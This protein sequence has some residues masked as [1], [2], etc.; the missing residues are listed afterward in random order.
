MEEKIDPPP[1]MS[2][3][4]GTPID[5]GKDNLK[6]V[7]I[8]QE[9]TEP[10][11]GVDFWERVHAQ[12]ML[13]DILRDIC[14]LGAQWKVAADGQP[15]QLKK[16]D[17]TPLTRGWF[18]FVRRSIMPSSNNSEAEVK[19]EKILPNQFLRIIESTSAK[20]RLSFSS[21]IQRLCD[22]AG[23]RMEENE[24]LVPMDQPITWAKMLKV[25]YGAHVHGQGK[26][27]HQQQQAQQQEAQQQAPLK[28]HGQFGW[29]QLQMALQGM[30]AHQVQTNQEL[31]H[32]IAQ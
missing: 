13:D 26:E 17:L 28:P 5:F 1:Y 14:V 31:Q 29:Y 19:V 3:V 23:V 12:P 9:P 22:S 7:L 24:I 6:K 8:I 2:Y 30:Q 21:I 20:S 16:A 10:H 18:E 32:L 25:G 11:E 15:V 27:Q 4:R